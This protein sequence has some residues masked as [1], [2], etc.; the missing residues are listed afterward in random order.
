MSKRQNGKGTLR[1]RGDGR[2]EGRFNVGV[3]E[4]G[5]PKV[6]YILAKTQAE[7]AR[8]LKAAIEE[9]E[10]DKEIAERCTFLTNPNPTLSEWSAI[11]LS[12]YCKGIIREST[13]ENYAYFFERYINPRIGAMEIRIISTIICQQL[14]MEL[15]TKGR[16]IDTSQGKAGTGYSLKTVK[17][18]KIALQSCLQKAED[19]E[20][21]S[22]NPVKGVKL[23]KLQK[24]EMKTLKVNELS[25]FLNETIRSDC[26]EFYFLE[27]TTGLR[28][29]EILALE[30][31]DLDEENKTIRVNKQVRRSKN[32][33]EVSTPKTQ[34]SIRTISI[35][36][37]CLTLLKGLKAKQP[38][39]TKL[40]FPSPVTGSY[41]DPKSVTYR[42]HRIQR[43]A[44]VPQIR[45]HDLRHSFAT[46]SIE[47]GMDIKTI[48]YMLGHTDAGF[49]MNTYMHVT[50][51]MQQNVADT[52]GELLTS[53][54]DENEEKIIKFPA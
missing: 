43:R 50:D 27:I 30:W 12:S 4:N 32:G 6:K 28:L 7:C 23:P 24:K 38:V 54:K 45:F 13:Y 42:L 5:K 19:E 35:S 3:N 44:G 29:G 9:Y 36:T 1:K 20:L 47:Q 8:K 37:E 10:H 34:A 46:L 18:V 33:M 17:N 40:M 31:E 14:L 2:W 39:G 15:Y 49:T 16:L 52:M 26:Y 53:K 25:A 51:S 22:G 11:W 21:I 41:Y 48:S